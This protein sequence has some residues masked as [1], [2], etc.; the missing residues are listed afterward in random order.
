MHVGDTLEWVAGG[1]GVAAAFLFL[2]WPLALLAL[3]LLFGYEAQCLADREIT[4]PRPQIAER[5]RR[6]RTQR[7]RTKA[8]R[9]S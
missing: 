6:R 4:I 5:L 7:R 2:G 9:L 3:M 1:C 8:R